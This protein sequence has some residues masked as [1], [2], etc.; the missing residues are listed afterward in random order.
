[1]TPTLF[2]LIALIVAFT[3]LVIWVWNPRTRSRWEEASQLPFDGE[4]EESAND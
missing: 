1:M 3:A 4:P 2:S